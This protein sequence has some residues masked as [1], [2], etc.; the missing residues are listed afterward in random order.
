M[1]SSTLRLFVPEFVFD[2]APYT[3]VVELSASIRSQINLPASID[4]IRTLKQRKGTS[5]IGGFIPEIPSKILAEIGIGNAWVVK[6]MLTKLLRQTQLLDIEG[7]YQNSSVILDNLYSRIDRY[8]FL[9][10]IILDANLDPL[11]VDEIVRFILESHG[12]SFIQ[13]AMAFETSKKDWMILCSLQ[14][15][16]RNTMTF[17]VLSVIY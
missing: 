10:L 14:G 16:N 17:K 4:L 9:R 1:V 6:Q 15:N 7:N 11:Q 12:N 2:D 3:L 8:S 5:V 13:T